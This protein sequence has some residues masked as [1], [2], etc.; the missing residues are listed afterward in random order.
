MSLGDLCTPAV[1]PVAHSFGSTGSGMCT[2][3]TPLFSPIPYSWHTT[4]LACSE[5]GSS[6]A[7]SEY[8]SRHKMANPGLV[9]TEQVPSS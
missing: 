6:L 8:S 3:T 9:G 5:Q 2:L 4:A 7:L 1:E